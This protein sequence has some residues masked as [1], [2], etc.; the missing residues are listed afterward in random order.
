MAATNLNQYYTGLGQS[1]PSLSTRAQTYQTAG[2]GDASGYAGS[3]AQNTALLNYL[4]SQ[5]V[6]APAATTAAA[7]AATAATA[8]ATASPSPAVGYD[9]NNPYA[10]VVSSLQSSQA[11]LGSIYDPQTTAL[12]TQ[13]TTVG[14]QYQ[15][16]LNTLKEQNQTQQ[17]GLQTAET[18]DTGAQVVKAFSGGNVGY[19][20]QDIAALQSIKTNYNNQLL[21]LNEQYKQAA[22]STS[23]Q[24]DTA[25]ANIGNQ[26][27]QVLAAKQQADSDFATK[28]AEAQASGIDY[29]NKNNQFQQQMAESQRE[30]EAQM[31]LAR[32]TLDKSSVDV[33]DPSS[34]TKPDVPATQNSTFSRVGNTNDITIGTW[35]GS[36]ED[37]ATNRA[38]TDNRNSQAWQNAYNEIMSAFPD[39]NVSYEQVS[40][41]INKYIPL[42]K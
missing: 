1:L 33:P 19:G 15:D 41:A 29:T 6:S 25:M 21:N 31:A 36:R 24:R 16:Y 23:D 32:A 18:G 12:Q 13:Q 22:L 20:S 38:G 8:T 14:K 42:L 26:I 34:K 39:V 35:V 30:F 9:P 7:P 2:L 4:Q 40:S 28:I 17:Q 10:G 5:G 27:T 37:A 11:K 3:V